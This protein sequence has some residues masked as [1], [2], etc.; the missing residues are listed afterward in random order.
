M[1]SHDGDDEGI[2]AR[3]AVTISRSPDLRLL[4][5]G[6][7]FALSTAVIMHIYNVHS[8]VQV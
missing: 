6:S 5:R 7:S 8:K 3:A 1:E 2:G 4:N